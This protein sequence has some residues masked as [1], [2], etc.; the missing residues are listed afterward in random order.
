ML[1]I[2][3]LTI[4]L[5]LV[6]NNILGIIVIR[7]LKRDLEY[8]KK[9]HRITADQLK[10]CRSAFMGIEDYTF[11]TE[12]VNTSEIRNEIRSCNKDLECFRADAGYLHLEYYGN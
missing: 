6:I 5:A 3:L 12:T 10:R 2:I 8:E 11:A 7:R 4:M 1:T 9:D